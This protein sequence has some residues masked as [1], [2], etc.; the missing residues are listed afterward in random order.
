[1]RGSCGGCE[2]GLGTAGPSAVPFSRIRVYLLL[3]TL[4]YYIIIGVGYTPHKN[5]SYE[6][7][8]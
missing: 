1:M 5:I 4:L 7:G 2:R 6:L 8:C 3:E